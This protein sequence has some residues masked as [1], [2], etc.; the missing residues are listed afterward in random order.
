[1]TRETSLASLDEAITELRTSIKN[2]TDA[3]VRKELEKTLKN[4]M[5]AREKMNPTR[6]LS[7][8]Y[9]VIIPFVAIFAMIGAYYFLHAGKCADRK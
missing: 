7:S 6:P 8:L 3:E 1:M 2:V 9:V 5:K 4:L